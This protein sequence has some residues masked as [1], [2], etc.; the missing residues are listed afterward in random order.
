M[1]TPGRDEHLAVRDVVEVEGLPARERRRPRPQVDD[2]LE[3]GA[4]GA[5]GK[6]GFTQGLAHVEPAQR[7][8]ARPRL[9]LLDEGP[10][11]DARLGQH[12]R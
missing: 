4:A 11:V 2:D 5:A 8:V 12:C 9:V 1:G 3:D 7:P 10:G 6:L